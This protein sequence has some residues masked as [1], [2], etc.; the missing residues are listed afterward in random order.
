MFSFLCVSSLK[1]NPVDLS[2]LYTLFRC[3]SDSCYLQDFCRRPSWMSRKGKR[4]SRWRNRGRPPRGSAC[5]QSWGTSWPS[6]QESRESRQLRLRLSAGRQAATGNRATG[7][8]YWRAWS[9]VEKEHRW[10]AAGSRG[11]SLGVIQPSE[12]STLKMVVSPKT[13]GFLWSP[14]FEWLLT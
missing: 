13:Q 2:R 6:S 12:H 8:R 5:H 11:A 7:G 14:Q 4:V 9:S 10:S 1:S 3:K